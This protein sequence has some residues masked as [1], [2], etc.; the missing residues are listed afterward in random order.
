MN[1][2]SDEKESLRISESWGVRDHAR[3]G[4]SGFAK[5][6]TERRAGREPMTSHC[7]SGEI[8]MVEALGA[9]TEE[10]VLKDERFKIDAVPLF[11]RYAAILFC[12]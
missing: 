5:D 4:R 8:A 10:S 1:W 6:Q 9:G 12:E 3:V 7:P 2:L 11:V